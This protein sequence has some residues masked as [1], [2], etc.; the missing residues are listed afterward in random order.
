MGVRGRRVTA[1]AVLR[2]DTWGAQAVGLAA[3]ITAVGVIWRKVLRPIA[4]AAKRNAELY[5]YLQDEFAAR[6]GEGK[7]R[8]QV[9]RIEMAQSG[10][11]VL[12]E[13]LMDISDELVTKVDKLTKT[14]DQ[15]AEAV[16]EVQQTIDPT[17]EG[18]DG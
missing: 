13:R 4:I 5:Q 3:I 1:L 6:N 11:A 15:T 17:P 9:N 14:A 2:F 8:D 7:L 16:H 10:Q 18:S 12:V